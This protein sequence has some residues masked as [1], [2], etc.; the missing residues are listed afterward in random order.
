[1]KLNASKTKELRI[2]FAKKLN[3]FP[4]ISI[5]GEHIEKV[6]AARVLGVTVSQDLTWNQH[7]SKIVSKANQRLFLLRQCKRCNMSTR[8]MI[9]LYSCKVRSI[10]EY[11]CQ[12]WHP[13]LPK[14]LHKD[15]EQLQHRAL[16]MIFPG[17]T[18]DESL[19]AS[20]LQR[21]STRRQNH[22]LKFMKQMTDPDHKLHHLLPPT[23]QLKYNL[24]HHS[25]YPRP[26]TNTRRADGCLINW[27]LENELL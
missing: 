7:V 8:D 3:H 5:E 23:R 10:L 4:A 26:T 15:I 12:V 27:T 9:D 19:E 16:R 25:R 2:S 22:C 17:K 6:P 1:M 18:Y 14:Y 11:G 24:R 13:R 20:G 21:L